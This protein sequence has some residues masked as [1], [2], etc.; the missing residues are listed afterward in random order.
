MMA[1]I[2]TP[3]CGTEIAIYVP[4]YMVPVLALAVL[5]AYLWLRRIR[6]NDP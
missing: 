5:V 1:G 6:R 4:V 2:A 3:V